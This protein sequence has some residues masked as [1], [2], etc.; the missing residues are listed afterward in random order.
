[1]I[2]D[3]VCRLAD[4]ERAGHYSVVFK[5][6]LGV[7]SV[8]CIL[9]RRQRKLT[10]I[11]LS[12]GC[13]GPGLAC[14]SL[15]T[16]SGLYIIYISSTEPYLLS[17]TSAYQSPPPPSPSPTLHSG[18]CWKSEVKCDLDNAAA[19]PRE[20]LISYPVAELEGH[21]WLGPRPGPAVAPRAALRT[22]S[23]QISGGAGLLSPWQ[24]SRKYFQWPPALK[25]QNI[26]KL[27][28]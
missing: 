13:P 11:S 9:W 14:Q 4:C 20:D 8:N 18:W 23:V 24:F 7:R 5:D 28:K 26:F 16:L 12:S 6:M 15:S 19:R 1:M 10:M 17:L 2:Y 21:S 22:G 27:K 3:T 25:I